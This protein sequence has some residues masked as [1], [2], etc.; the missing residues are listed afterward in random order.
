M[1]HRVLS[2]GPARFTVA[3]PRISGLVLVC[4]VCGFLNPQGAAAQTGDNSILS[5][6]VP[7]IWSADIGQG[8]R[9]GAQEAGLSVGAGFGM[10]VL[11]TR[12]LHDWALGAV[13]YGRMLTGVLAPDRWYGGNLEFIGSLFGLGQYRTERGYAVGLTPMLRYDF[14]IGSRV[15]PFFGVGAGAT[16]T[17]IRGGDLSTDFEFNLQ[18]GGGIDIFLRENLAL[19]LEYRFIHLSN[20]SWS[21]PNLGVNTSNLLVGLSWFF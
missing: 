6:P 7:S 10:R 14:A 15:V 9:R 16:F 19:S 3:A 17:N 1:H 5:G 20:A 8:F 13:H 12:H 21:T 18:G 4:A 11:G 2:E